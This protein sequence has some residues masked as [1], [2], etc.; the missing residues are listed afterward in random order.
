MRI[1]TFPEERPL[2]VFAL[3]AGAG[4]LAGRFLPEV[5]VFLCVCG[6]VSGAAAFLLA[7]NK[8]NGK[9]LT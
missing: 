5:P 6:M 4:V 1:G 2:A 8:I 7:K 3:C 9:I